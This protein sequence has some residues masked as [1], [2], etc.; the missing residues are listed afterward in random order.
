MVAMALTHWDIEE[1]L[2]VRE[3]NI[4]LH[5]FCLLSLLSISQQVLFPNEKD[6]VQQVKEHRHGI[7]FSVYT[8]GVVNDIDYTDISSQLKSDIGLSSI[9]I[10]SGS[11]TQMA[12]SVVKSIKTSVWFLQAM[13]RQM[14]VL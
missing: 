1:K 4:C 7:P 9:Q 12:S 13:L 5:T 6:I 14:Q 3:W 10:R 2:K 11:L 8:S